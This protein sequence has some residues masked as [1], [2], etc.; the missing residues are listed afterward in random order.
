MTALTLVKTDLIDVKPHSDY[1][2]RARVCVCVFE[3]N[4]MR[5][6]RKKKKKSHLPICGYLY[7]EYQATQLETCKLSQFCQREMQ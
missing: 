5:R 7:L 4:K 2:F 3:G 6:V 1:I